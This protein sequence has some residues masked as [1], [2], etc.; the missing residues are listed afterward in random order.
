MGRGESSEVSV[1]ICWG[2]KVWGLDNGV[3][4]CF[5]GNYFFVGDMWFVLCALREGSVKPFGTR[6]RAIDQ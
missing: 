6:V 3:L 1:L 2:W 4:G 5:R